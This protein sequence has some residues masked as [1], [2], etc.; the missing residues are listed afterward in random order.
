[1]HVSPQGSDLST[2]TAT[3]I[4]VSADLTFRATVEN[5]GDFPEVNVPVR[6]VI[7]AGGKPITRVKRI[8]S[9]QPTEQTTVD[10]S[11]FN[12]PPAAF[13]NRATVTVTVVKVPGETNTSNNS[14]SYTVFFTLTS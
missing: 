3:T 10:F 13:G 14:A 1:V 9:I 5:S 8:P 7:D 2:S 12:L 4:K 6:L 11:N